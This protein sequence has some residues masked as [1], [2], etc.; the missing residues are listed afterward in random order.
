MTHI[1][2]STLSRRGF[3]GS[4]TGLVLSCTL[5]AAHAAE[6]RNAGGD[7]MAYLHI[8]PDNTIT[9]Q[10]GGIEMGQGVIS[11]LPKILCEDLEADFSLVTATL[12]PAD[13]AFANPNKKRQT[14]GN[15]DAVAGYGPQMRKIGAQA[16]EMLIAAAAKQWNVAPAA[17]RAENSV[18]YHDASKRSAT[19]GQLAAAAAKM[20]VPE[21]PKLKPR[22]QFKLICKP[23]L[24][25]DTPA[26]VDG[27]AKFGADVV[28]PG[29]LHATVRTCPVFGGVVKS[30]DKAAKFPGVQKLVELTDADGKVNGIGVIADGFW[31]AKK[32]AD[33]L[34]IEWD[35]QGNERFNTADM[36]RAL[37]TSLDSDADAKPLTNGNGKVGDVP[38][39]MKAAAKTW[40]A[41]Y[42]A[43]YLAH[44]CMEP[45]A[46]TC[47]VEAGRVEMW[48]PAQQQGEARQ[49]ASTLTGVPF[50]NVR[51]NTMFAGGGFGRKWELDFIRQSILLAKAM[52]GRPVRMMWTREED[53]QHATFRPAYV[54][55]ISAAL[56]KDGAITGM[57]A[58][59][60]GQSLFTAQ[61]RKMPPPMIDPT[62]T[63]GVISSAY[64]IPNT[65]IDYVEAKTHMPVG[66]WRSV[67]AS[68]AGFFSESAI[69]ELAVL[70]GKDPIAF[71]KAAVKDNARAL[72]VLDTVAEM[73]GWGRKLQAG[74][75]LGVS[76]TPGFD[77]L[78]AQVAQVS[79]TKGELKVE[80]IWCVY[81]AGFIVEPTTVVAQMEGGIIFG[82]S[83]ALFGEITVERGAVK[84]GNFIDYG[85]VTLANAP[86]IEVKV[87]E[88]DT[89]PGG[90]GEASV[91]GIAPAVTNAIY[92]ATGNRIRK[93]PI[94]NAGLTM[95]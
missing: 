43:P 39:A 91:P 29:L 87:I 69:D 31:Q 90:A 80:K 63:G 73:S 89:K 32:A 36:T 37:L 41:T 81:D 40:S 34:H 65:L 12:A 24:R 27:S 95:A 62:A 44:A 78:V 76:F 10:C 19:Y 38:A 13:I 52:P 45:M 50:E 86:E 83:A 53:I 57:H 26:K 21:N 93:L 25:K 3:V 60:A 77:A 51:M 85:M 94:R 67:G 66:Y 1:S 18:V 59:L 28:L 92:A 79:I 20:P 54:G 22:D 11:S 16:K 7:F 74:Q 14:T 47:V 70:A 55:R 58:R 17:C 5:P 56:D 75:G 30:Y 2:R 82:L 6:M 46:A 9:I 35:T 61:K 88:S 4:A 72:K 64:V 8:A 49:L 23:T 84:Q 71:R 33:A 48:A 42:E 15:S 68:Y